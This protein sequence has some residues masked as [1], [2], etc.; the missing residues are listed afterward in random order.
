MITNSRVGRPLDHSKDTAI[1]D[2]AC[3]LMFAKG[4]AKMSMEA[5]ARQAG[6]SKV[7]LY[8]RFAD[9]ETLIDAV[10]QQLSQRINGTLTVSPND[11]KDCH[12]ALSEFGLLLLNFIVSHE[13]MNL[14]RMMASISEEH[15]QILHNIYSGG[16]MAAHQALSE[17][18]TLKHKEGLINCADPDF[19]AEMFL[20]MITGLDIVRAFHLIPPRSVEGETRLHVE[21]VVSSFLKLWQLE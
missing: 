14:M 17:W 8:K 21:K 18:L 2:A 19:G 1:L 13:H 5:I 20:S 9:K 15:T 4:P 7:T 16:V 10:I 12:H 11:Y 6:V 3:A